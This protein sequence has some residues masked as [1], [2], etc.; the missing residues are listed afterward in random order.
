MSQE[1][2]NTYVI[3]IIEQSTLPSAIAVSYPDVALDRTTPEGDYGFKLSGVA[4]DNREI[5]VKDFFEVRTP[6]TCE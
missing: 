1:K 4:L 6:N 3:E 5:V 2:A